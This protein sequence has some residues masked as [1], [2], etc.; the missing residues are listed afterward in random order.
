MSIVVHSVA[1]HHH[2]AYSQQRLLA[3]N[4]RSPRHKSIL[5]GMLRSDHPRKQQGVETRESLLYCLAI[6][7]EPCDPDLALARPVKFAEQN[8]LPRTQG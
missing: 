8:P 2:G 7:T 3:R 4:A 5:G 6:S 1:Q